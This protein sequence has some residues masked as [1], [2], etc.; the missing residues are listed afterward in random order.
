MQM[1]VGAH[2]WRCCFDPC[3]FSGKTVLCSV[4]TLPP[5]PRIV[6]AKQECIPL[7]PPA[8]QGDYSY[9]ENGKPPSSR[10]SSTSAAAFF[11]SG[12]MPKQIFESEFFLQKPQSKRANGKIRLPLFFV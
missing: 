10:L 7:V 8:Q 4:F 11:F 12:K 2:T 6:N 1:S 5:F 3:V 9:N